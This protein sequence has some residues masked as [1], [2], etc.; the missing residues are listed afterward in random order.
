MR[1]FFLLQKILGREEEDRLS[2]SSWRV[3]HLILC[4]VQILDL[5]LEHAKNTANHVAVSRAKLFGHYF[6]TT[7]TSISTD[8]ATS[9]R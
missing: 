8:V 7:P 3:L 9:W 6:P 1:Q 4:P 5:V 2:L